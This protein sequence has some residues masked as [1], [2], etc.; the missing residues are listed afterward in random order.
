MHSSSQY[1]DDE[2]LLSNRPLDHGHD[3]LPGSIHPIHNT[4]VDVDHP[5][6]KIKRIQCN[7]FIASVFFCIF[8]AGSILNFMVCLILYVQDFDFFADVK[9]LWM[10]A[11]CVVLRQACSCTCCMLS[12]IPPCV[13]PFRFT[14]PS[15]CSLICP[16]D[17][18]EPPL[19]SNCSIPGR[20]V[21]TMESYWS[22]GSPTCFMKF[23]RSAVVEY[24]LGGELRVSNIFDV[25]F[26]VPNTCLHRLLL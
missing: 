5:S 18:V 16:I 2:N 22:P 3:D 25:R 24:I 19:D 7:P 6:V 23:H 1:R 26:C 9:Q 17:D 15:R 11:T 13:C 8:V 4:D 10:P 21:Q 12:P 14:K 20:T